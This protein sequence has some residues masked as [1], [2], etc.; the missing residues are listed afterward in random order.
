MVK[1][2]SAGKLVAWSL[3]DNMIKVINDLVEQAVVP[4]FFLPAVI[5]AFDRRFHS[6]FLLVK[7]TS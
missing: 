4:S 6:T 5:S 7:I 1:K 3:G 2:I